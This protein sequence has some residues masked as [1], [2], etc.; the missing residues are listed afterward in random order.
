MIQAAFSKTGIT[1]LTT[2]VEINV[3]DW[4]FLYITFTVGS[5]ALT[6]FDIAYRAHDSG[7]YA[8]LA[9]AAGDFTSP[10]GIVIDASASPVTAAADGTVYGVLLNVKAAQS[11]RIRA[12]S[13]TTSTMS[14]HYRASGRNI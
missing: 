12:S 14:G 3:T 6:A 4:E 10:A 8:V 11:V 5:A 13:G 1:T 9:N 7:G 2:V